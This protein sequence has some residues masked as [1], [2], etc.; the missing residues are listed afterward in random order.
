MILL[1][2]TIVNVGK[3]SRLFYIMHT[4]AHS[5]PFA[6]IA[7]YYAVLGRCDKCVKGAGVQEKL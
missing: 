7:Y 2:H 6:N 1:L 4:F 3:T 5:M